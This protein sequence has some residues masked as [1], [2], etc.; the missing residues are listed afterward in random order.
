MRFFVDR[1]LSPY[2]ARALHALS[3]PHGIEVAHLDSKFRRD[4]PDREWI[5]QLAS[6]GEWAIVT[7]DRLVRNPIER[8]ALKSTGILTFVLAKGWAQQAEW[9]KAWHLVRWWPTL[10]KAAEVMG[11]GTYFVPLQFSGKGKLEPVSL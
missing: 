11:S 4:T 8:Q 1:N 3:E 9:D 2:L 7:Q 5:E 6:E 10:I